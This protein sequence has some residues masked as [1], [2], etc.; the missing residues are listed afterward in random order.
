[1]VIRSQWQQR[2]PAG[3]QGEGVTQLAAHSIAGGKRSSALHGDFCEEGAGAVAQSL[4]QFW[5]AGD[6]GSIRTTAGLPNL[7]AKFDNRRTVTNGTQRGAT[8]SVHYP[9]GQGSD[10][11]HY[12][13]AISRY[14]PGLS[15]SFRRVNENVMQP[16]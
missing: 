2:A 15:F 12:V 13:Q 16:G 9:S 11:L 14:E 3:E 8:V 5:R 10:N 7:M 1:M 6:V 4:S